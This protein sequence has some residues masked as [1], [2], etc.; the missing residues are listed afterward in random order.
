MLRMLAGC[1]LDNW[2]QSVLGKVT[3][4]VNS[5][6]NRLTQEILGLVLLRVSVS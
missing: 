5:N 1:K 3:C 6:L 4:S 2:Q